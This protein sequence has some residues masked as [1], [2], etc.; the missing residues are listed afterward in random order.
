MSSA[1][2]DIPEVPE[3]PK[4]P[5]GPAAPE[6]GAGAGVGTADAGAESHAIAALSIRRLAPQILTG[7]V[8]PFV[9]YELGRH[10]GLADPTA[11]ALSALPPG[12]SVVASWAWRKRLDPIGLIA[13]IAIVAGLVAMAFL[14]GN[15]V[16]FKVR[17]SVVTGAFGFLCL[18]SLVLPVKPAMFVMGRALT[19]DATSGSDAS[20]ER[21]REFDA[22]WE[23]PRARKVFVLLTLVWGIGLL[24]EACLRTSLVFVLS[25]GAFLAVTPALFWLVLG[26]LLWFTVTYVRSSRRLAV[27]DAEAAP[28]G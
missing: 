26:A 14:N 27:S 11:L 20:E 16:L 18:V 23:E 6:P 13:L 3:A 21:V 5:E 4:V 17:E 7:G 12:V 9:V 10:F 24:G 15:E 1:L 28:S 22:L 2:P 8:A 19:G 25:T